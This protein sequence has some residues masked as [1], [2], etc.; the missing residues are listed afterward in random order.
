MV[1]REPQGASRT[2]VTAIGA[3]NYAEY[4]WHAMTKGR[5]PTGLPIGQFSPCLKTCPLGVKIPIA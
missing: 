2:R 3:K 1:L 5:A 4:R